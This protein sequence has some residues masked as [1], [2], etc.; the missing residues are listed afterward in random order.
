M[1][2]PRRAVRI[3]TVVGNGNNCCSPFP[4][5]SPATETNAPIISSMVFGLSLILLYFASTLYHSAKDTARKRKLK[6]FDHACIYV[7]IAGS[8]TPF[9][10]GPLRGP[11]G[12]SLFCIIW[13][14]A[15]CG[16]VFKLRFTG[17]FKLVSTLIYVGMGWI[18]IFALTPLTKSLPKEAVQGM[19][20]GGLCYTLGTVFYLVKKIPYHHGFWHLSVLAGSAFHYFTVLFYIVA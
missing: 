19:F 17:R 12:W 14:L 10:L 4:E 16:V 7:L 9:T 5:T 13:A 6:V 18:A 20:A 8:Y 2:A 11:W 15:L 3:T 1:S